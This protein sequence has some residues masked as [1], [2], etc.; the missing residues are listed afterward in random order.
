MSIFKACDIRGHYGTQLLDEHARQLGSALAT[1]C[2]QV[3]VL[4]GGDGRIST[5]ALKQH[6]IEALVQGGCHVIDIGIVPTPVLY[7]ARRHLGVQAGVIV[8]AS[9]NPPADN[10]FKLAL[11]EL[12]ITPDQIETIAELMSANT[13]ASNAKTPGS[14]T[15]SVIL[16][17]YT[18]FARQ[19]VGR[20]DGMCIV[21]DCANGMAAL[22]AEQVWQTTGANLSYLFDAVDGSFPNHAPDPSNMRNLKS[23]CAAVIEQHADLGVAYDGDAD[24]VVFVDSLGRP[25]S[26]DRAIV[27]FVRQ[28]LAHGAAPIVYDQKCSLIVADAIRELGGMP[29][30]ERSGHTFIKT[31]FQNYE[32]PYAGEISGHHFFRQIGGDDGLIA[33]LYMADLIHKSGQSLAKLADSIHSYPI[34]PDIRLMM[35]SET[36][37]R[38]LRDLTTALSGE[39]HL[40]TLD[41]IR[42]EYADGWGMARLSV[43]EPAMTLRFEGKTLQ[44]LRRIMHRFE[45]DSP[46]LRGRL[47]YDFVQSSDTSAT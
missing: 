32:A 6:L 5:P 23:L 27:L 44:S 21:A 38:V 20:L 11:G 9:H 29:V 36:A 31:A 22:T 40:V 46:D 47:P 15:Q 2:G 25:L 28:A 41:G 4:V 13:L 30:I 24:R 33:S 34:T 8:T 37:H 18:E 26:G 14:V 39:A 12:P 35:D 19:Q 45:E 42:A 43:T 17:T 7:F 1:Y 16:P 10:G 3:D